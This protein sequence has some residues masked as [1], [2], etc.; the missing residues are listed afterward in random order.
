MADFVSQM[1]HTRADPISA[2]AQGAQIR[3][4]FMKLQQQMQTQAFNSTL[5]MMKM[6]QNQAEAKRRDEIGFYN[7][8]TQRMQTEALIDQRSQPKYSDPLDQQLMRARIGSYERANQPKTGGSSGFSLPSGVYNPSE[9]GNMAGSGQQQSGN[10][11]PT[12]NLF[13]NPNTASGMNEPSGDLAYSNRQ[14]ENDILMQEQAIIADGGTAPPDTSA[15]PSAGSGVL[16]PEF[17]NQQQTKPTQPNQNYN[18]QEAQDNLIA[19]GRA[20]AAKNGT[21]LVNQGG[22]MSLIRNLDGVE[23]IA[24]VSVG[25]RGLTTGSFSK[26]GSDKAKDKEVD[27]IKAQMDQVELEIKQAEL[28]KLKSPELPKA[29][30]KVVEQYSALRSKLFIEANKK[31]MQGDPTDE[32]KEAAFSAQFGTKP[33]TAEQWQQA[34]N[35]AK[36]GGNPGA[37]QE[38]IRLLEEQ[39]PTLNQTN[40]QAQQAPRPTIPG[41]PPQAPV[42]QQTM[43]PGQGVMRQPSQSTPPPKFDLTDIKTPNERTQQAP[44]DD[45]KIKAEWS[46]AKKSVAINGVTQIDKAKLSDAVQAVNDNRADKEQQK[47]YDALSVAKAIVTGEKYTEQTDLGMGETRESAFNAATK[48]ASDYGV[49]DRKIGGRLVRGKELLRLWAEEL[50]SSAGLDNAGAKQWEPG[51]EA[52]KDGPA[53]K[54]KL[55]AQ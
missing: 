9:L 46:N 55:R 21:A 37:V 25:V 13:P 41:A 44:Q 29:P 27:P 48:F 45:P 5:E 34:Y 4:E 19:Q 26:I 40:R 24:P 20:L 54:L 23:E 39:F 12:G 28:A 3:A 6:Q 7:A 16:R 17:Q 52:V 35:L 42:A 32:Q 8:Q 33:Q 38:E 31:P 36:G 50:L 18:S 2:F 30:E 1:N 53:G 43:A 14:L 10:F 15:N 49:E 47:L 11:E 51:Q 22:I